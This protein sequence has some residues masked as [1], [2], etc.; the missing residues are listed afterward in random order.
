MNVHDSP[1]PNSSPMLNSGPELIPSIDAPY[2]GYRQRSVPPEDAELTH[3]GPGTPCGE[4]MRKYWQPVCLSQELKDLPKAIR[5]LGEDLVAFRDG[6]GEVGIVHKHCSH[7]GTSLEYGIVS[8]RGIRCCY[9]G[10]LFDRDGTILETPG[11]PPDSRLKES[12]VHGAYPTLERDG[13]VFA[14]MGPPDE[15]PPFPMDPH[16]QTSDTVSKAYDIWHPCNWLQIQDN[17][18]DHLHGVFLHGAGLKTVPNSDKEED[19]MFSILPVLE[20]FEVDGGHG[21][22]YVATR[23]MPD[24]MVWVRCAQ[25]VLPTVFQAG[26]LFESASQEGTRRIGSTRWV[27]PVDDDSCMIFGWRH[28]NPAVDREGEGRPEVIGK[29]SVDFYGQTGGRPYEERQRHPG[30]WDAI[31]SQRPIAVHALEHLGTTDQ[32]VAMLRRILRQ[33][34]RGEL[35]PGNS[36]GASPGGHKHQIYAHD[37]V[38]KIPQQ[39][40]GND[41][42]LLQA[43][44]RHV[45][46]II[47]DDKAETVSEHPAV[48]EA[49]L[50][51]IKENL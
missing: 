12:F 19:P 39:D 9:H 36:T 28:Y 45:T 31:V 14:Y 2:G 42:E 47:L 25:A 24:D 22:I 48:L 50:A 33:G 16:Y 35:G 49:R 29:E 15:K 7:R 11:E 5:I 1:K 23:R 8:D 26:V 38:L 44:G 51:E 6:S 34:I 10:W 37:T 18:M 17:I 13:L 3:T 27:V 43:V 20:H 32:G 4:F 40:G 41:R 21:M 46:E 30:D